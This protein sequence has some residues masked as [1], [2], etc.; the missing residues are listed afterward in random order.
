[1]KEE[2]EMEITVYHSDEKENRLSLM[3]S[4]AMPYVDTDVNEVYGHPGD[5]EAD[6]L[7]I[8]DDIEYQTVLGI[9]GAF[10]ESAALAWRTLPEEKQ[11]EFIE[12]YFDSEKG[13][14]YNFGRLSIASCDFS[15]EDYTYVTEGD[16]TLDSFDIS[17]DKAAVFPMVKAARKLS[18]LLLFASPWSPPAYMKTNGERIFG[19]HLKKE[20]YPLWAKYF[21]KYIEA[22]KNE[23]IDIW[24]V[25]LQNEPRH[26]QMWESCLYSPEEETEFLG[27][28]GKELHNTGVKI[29]CYDHCRERVYERSKKIFE[30]ESGEFCDGIAHHWY[31]GDHFGE[32]EAFSRRYPD[33]LNIASEGCCAISGTGINPDC[34]LE[35]AEKYAHDILGCFR[36]GLN[37]YCDWNLTLNENNGPY[38]NREGRGCSAD[39]PVYCNAE[40]GEIV[41]RLPYYYIGHISKFVKRG[42]KVINSSSYTEALDSCAF[43]NPDGEIV[44]VVMNTASTSKNLIVRREGCIHKTEMPPHTI[45]TFVINN[46]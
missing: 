41:Y 9:G 10:S 21:R 17:H 31:S 13:I 18:D 2:S 5:I 43:K 46:A 24:G 23:G 27:Y 37:A 45:S 3:G 14:G 19:G 32:L 42:A 7:N 35:F 8:H 30:S 38:H 22:C 15:Y 33:K 12:A 16:Q 1:M 36:H 20:Y 29:F 44:L 39:A 26:T 6:V 40:S 4:F 11:K 34:E 25:T 28:L